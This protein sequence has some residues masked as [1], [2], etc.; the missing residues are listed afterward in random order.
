MHLP[1]HY[2]RR[3]LLGIFIHSF[4]KVQACKRWCGLPLSFRRTRVDPHWR[5]LHLVDKRGASTSL[6]WAISGDSFPQPGAPVPWSAECR[7]VSTLTVVWLQWPECTVDTLSKMQ[8]KTFWLLN[9]SGITL[10]QTFTYLCCSFSNSELVESR[11][12]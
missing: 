5:M 9:N 12:D 4:V 1:L 2:L 10:V 3:Y 11:K 8:P 6:A 7:H